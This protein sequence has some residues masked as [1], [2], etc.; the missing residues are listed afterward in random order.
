MQW[1]TEHNPAGLF[2]HLDWGFG[3]LMLGT[4]H[5]PD[6]H[7]GN[8]YLMGMGDGPI[9]FPIQIYRYL[10]DAKHHAECLLRTKLISIAFVLGRN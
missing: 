6:E 2:Y 7:E 5:N 8:W 3:S 10:P 1:I 9:F 4:W